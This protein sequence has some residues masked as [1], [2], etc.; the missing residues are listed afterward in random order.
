[1]VLE[2]LSYFGIKLS[3]NMKQALKWTKNCGKILKVKGG[4]QLPVPEAA[5]EDF[6]VGL[7]WDTGSEGIDIDSSVIMF[8]KEGELY[9]NI[10]F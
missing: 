3:E 4:E 10:S 6:V 5:Y 8:T 9:E 1:M 7:G 2:N